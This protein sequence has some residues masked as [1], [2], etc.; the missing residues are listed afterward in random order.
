MVEQ[1]DH[2]ASFDIYEVAQQIYKQG[3]FESELMNPYAY[4][5]FPARGQYDFHVDFENKGSRPDYR[6]FTEESG[7][8]IIFVSRDRPFIMKAVFRLPLTPLNLYLRIIPLFKSHTRE[9]E[10]VLRCANHERQHPA[11]DAQYASRSFVN[12]QSP[13]ACYCYLEKH[14]TVLVPVDRRRIA[15]GLG[16]HQS[17]DEPRTSQSS[18]SSYP[19]GH[20]SENLVCRIGCYT[21]CLGGQS[22]GAVELLVRL[23]EL[24][25]DPCKQPVVFGTDRVE[26]HCSST[27]A[28]DIR[29]YCQNAATT[30]PK[31]GS[32]H[33]RR[34]LS[35]P[36]IVDTASLSS[37]SYNKR[38]LALTGSAIEN[39]S[40]Q[41]S[42][43]APRDSSKP[44]SPESVNLC[45]GGI[46]QRFYIVATRS[47]RMAAEFRLMDDSKAAFDGRRL[48]R[49]KF[50]TNREECKRAQQ[51]V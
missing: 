7:R 9:G 3:N 38:P 20:V 24:Q 41:E 29:V 42:D 17:V 8:R 2:D 30:T 26:V 10:V 19:M 51:I 39:S 27:P 31:R 1:V 48:S 49:T 44:S 45:V 13:C 4:R 43:A 11:A 6:L 16:Q 36:T 21:S 18:Q 37:P 46:K 40:S 12:V 5:R 32:H 50:M 35:E 33:R 23:E 47:K 14:L 15:M 34:G 25:S 28:R 22:R